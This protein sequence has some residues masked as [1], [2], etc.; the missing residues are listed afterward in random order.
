MKSKS[1]IV[2]AWFK[3]KEQLDKDGGGSAYYDE[4]AVGLEMILATVR[5]TARECYAREA[6]ETERAARRKMAEEI[7]AEHRA[8][9]GK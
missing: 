4:L 2:A 5:D 6:V 3:I 1:V 7:L 9:E 8:R